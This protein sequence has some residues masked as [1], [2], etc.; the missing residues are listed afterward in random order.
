MRNG[1]G[2]SGLEQ[3]RKAYYK[4]RRPPGMD[5]KRA[6]FGPPDSPDRDRLIDLKP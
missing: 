5:M 2:N 4:H 3:A 1:P 6:P